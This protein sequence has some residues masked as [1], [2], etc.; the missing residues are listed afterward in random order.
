MGLYILD[1]PQK[2]QGANAIND[3]GCSGDGDDDT[4]HGTFP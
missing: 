4:A 2:L 3:T 1:L